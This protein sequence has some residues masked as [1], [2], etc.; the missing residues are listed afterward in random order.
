MVELISR[1]PCWDGSGYDCR[2]ATERERSQDECSSCKGHGRGTEAPNPH[3]LASLFC[4]H[5]TQLDD[6]SLRTFI[7][8]TEAIVNS[9]P[10]SIDHNDSLEP[11][12]PN[13][14]LTMES[15]V[16]L[17]PSRC[18][19]TSG[20]ILKDT[21]AQSTTPSRWVRA[22]IE[23]GDLL[24]LMTRNKWIRARRNIQ[25]G[26]VAIVKDDNLPPNKWRLARA[27]EVF[28]SDDGLVR[29]D[30]V[31]VANSSL[32]RRGQRQEPVCCLER[33][34]P[35]IPNDERDWGTPSEEPWWKSTRWQSI[36]E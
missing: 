33:P 19:S 29:K 8:E 35:R 22:Q 32:D 20:P 26:D 6:E 23:E 13:Y 1:T 24:S 5:G 17:P 4:H 30:K 28:P 15:K 11:L 3:R 16:V 34:V 9:R 18:L 36:A 12:T 31:M 10:F 14:L 21:L 7:I 25:F 27:A 2:G